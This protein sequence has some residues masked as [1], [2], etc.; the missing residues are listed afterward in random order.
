LPSLNVFGIL[1]LVF[2]NANG[3]VDFHQPT[4]KTKNETQIT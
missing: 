2:C 4:L 1:C 3:H